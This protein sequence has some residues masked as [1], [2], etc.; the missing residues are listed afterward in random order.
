LV[1]EAIKALK[2][3]KVPG[4]NDAPNRRWSISPRQQ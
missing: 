2:V 3:G 4:P 1:Q